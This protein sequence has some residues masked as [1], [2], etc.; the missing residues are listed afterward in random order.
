MPADY[1]ITE[2][3]YGDRIHP[4]VDRLETLAGIIRSAYER[5]RTKNG[6]ILIPAFAVGR[7]QAVLYD[8]RQLMAE[9]RIPI[10]PVYVDGPMTIRSTAIHR[11][12]QELFNEKTAKL[13][14]AGIDPFTTPRQ[15]ETMQREQSQALD[16][17]QKEPFIIVG[18]SGMANG[19][20]I[21][22]HLLARLEDAENTVVFV[23]YQGTGTLG[24]ALVG[25]KIDPRSACATEV[26]IY[27][28]VVHVRATIE[29]I[30]AYSGHA[31]SAELLALFFRLERKPKMV[32][33]EHGTPPAL[34]GM[35]ALIE[36]HLGWNCVIPKL[37]DVFIL[38]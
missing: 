22:N 5:A 27:G 28:K 38:D 36:R 20:R 2:S 9:R 18:S 1:L 17:P 24:Q 33:I 6:A 11:K 4:K 32:F 19:G 3:T 23:G 26:R 21:V 14:Q 13:V 29:F 34:A 15:T 31:D 7:A 30:D 16:L 12:H 8:L 25:C 10:M 37:R 35:K